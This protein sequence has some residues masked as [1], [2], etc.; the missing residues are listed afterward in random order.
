MEGVEKTR[1]EMLVLLERNNGAHIDQGCNGEPLATRY[2]QIVRRDAA[3]KLLGSLKYGLATCY[4]CVCV[5]NVILVQRS[6]IL[7]FNLCLRP[8]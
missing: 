6:H 7:I 1:H 4:R 8:I 3:R 5:R 2:Q